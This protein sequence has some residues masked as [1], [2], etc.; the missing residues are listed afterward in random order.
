MSRSV[1]DLD[2]VESIDENKENQVNEELS[3]RK[4]ANTLVIEPGSE[5]KFNKLRSFQSKKDSLI[6]NL[7]NYR[8]FIHKK[9]S[10]NESPD[11]II[12]E[13]PKEEKSHFEEEVEEKVIILCY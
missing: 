9:E 5:I 6:D 11:I 8:T 3:Q 2:N 13:E 10:L 12:K 4:K 1:E 7:N